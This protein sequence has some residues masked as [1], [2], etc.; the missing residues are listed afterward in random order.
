V[1]VAGANYT[2]LKIMGEDLTGDNPFQ[3]LID[4]IPQAKGVMGEYTLVVAGMQFKGGPGFVVLAGTT[5]AG[6]L[7]LDST[8]AV[9][10]TAS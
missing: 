3:L 8:C 4:G 2:A 5:V 1:S 9:A 10:S 7:L 6:E